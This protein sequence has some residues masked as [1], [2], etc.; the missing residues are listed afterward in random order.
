[1]YK[2]IRCDHLFIAIFCVLYLFLLH[3][4]FFIVRF[5]DFLYVQLC[6]Y[7]G[8]PNRTNSKSNNNIWGKIRIELLLHYITIILAFMRL[9][10]FFVILCN[11][12]MEGAD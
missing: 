7:R 11:R 9:L 4:Q 2:R 10:H 5:L 1:M 6:L 8:I 12:R 3:N